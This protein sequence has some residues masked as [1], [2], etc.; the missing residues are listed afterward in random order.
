VRVTPGDGVVGGGTYPGV[1][2]SG[3]VL[4]V[5][6]AG[7]SAEIL[8]EALRS[9]DPPVVGRR[10]DRDLV[11]DLRTVDPELDGKLLEAL[12]RAFRL[13]GRNRDPS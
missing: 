10:E 9:G 5:R 2:L 8:A 1:T 13:A 3:W 12:R 11:L 4:R 7:S 6:G